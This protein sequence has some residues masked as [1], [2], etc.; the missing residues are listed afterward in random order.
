[1]ALVGRDVE[2][3][4]FAHVLDRA[5]AGHGEVLVLTGPRGAGKTALADA[6][7]DLAHHREFRVLRGGGPLVWAQLARDLAVPDEIIGPLLGEPDPLQ[8]DDVARR[9]VFPDRT[10]IVVDDVDRGGPAAVGL[11]AVL[12]GRI[13]A[14]RT[15]VVA[16]AT[17]SVGAGRE[18]RIGGLAEDELAAVLPSSR[19]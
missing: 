17:T 15:V 2:L 5:G 12:A 1:M 3:E 19:A 4:E 13:G 10:V 8:L 16:T 11:L 14:S 7:V 6:A 9:L 18:L